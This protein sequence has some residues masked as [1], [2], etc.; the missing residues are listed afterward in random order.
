MDGGVI[1]AQFGKI[2]PCRPI[3]GI[4]K[5]RFD[6]DGM[7]PGVMSGKATRRP[8]TLGGKLRL[9]V[10][11]HDRGGRS[12]GQA[13]RRRRRSE[14]LEDDAIN[15]KAEGI[16]GALGIGDVKLGCQ[17]RKNGIACRGAVKWVSENIL[18]CHVK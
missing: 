13:G 5:E 7:R 15:V 9:L 16:Q 3:V 4:A 18:K 6:Q 10:V 17:L 8:P 1:D 2:E 14:S 12:G 11:V